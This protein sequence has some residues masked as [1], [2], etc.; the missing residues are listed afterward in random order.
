MK[1]G[2]STR[3]SIVL[4]LLLAG[5]MEERIVYRNPLLGRVP[6]AQ[7]GMPVTGPKGAKALPT[8]LNPKDLRREG[9]DGSITLV[10]KNGQQLLYH[11]Q[12]TIRDEDPDLFVDEVLSES[13]RQEYYARNEDPSLA[14]LRIKDHED[15]LNALLRALPQGEYTP[16]VKTTTQPG[17]R[18]RRIEL[19][20]RAREGL[21]WVGVDLELEKGNWRLRWFVPNVGVD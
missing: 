6:G 13:T 17:G 9:A 14:Y 4:A 18:A 7:S 21:R 20:G 11:L 2:N 1:A 12:T 3:A 19:V 5:C 10:A 8:G 16:N 15:D